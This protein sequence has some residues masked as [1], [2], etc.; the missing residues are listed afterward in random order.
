MNK[1]AIAVLLF[2]ILI[3][4]SA[5][6]INGSNGK[7]ANE[8]SPVITHIENNITSI[9]YSEQYILRH[10]HIVNNSTYSFL[11]NFIL[12]QHHININ[13][14]SKN[15]YTNNVV[16][17]VP[18][19]SV[20]NYNISFIYPL[21]LYNYLLP[22]HAV[23][24]TQQIMT[25]V[26]SGNHFLFNVDIPV[27]PGTTQELYNMPGVTVFNSTQTFLNEYSPLIP[28]TY[29]PNNIN[30]LPNY[31]SYN[32]IKFK[33][34][35]QT[36]QTKNST[37]ATVWYTPT[38]NISAYYANSSSP[39]PAY[40]ITFTNNVPFNIT[41]AGTTYT[42]QTSLTVSEPNGTYYYTVTYN[43]STYYSTVVVSGQNIQVNI[44]SIPII[45]NTMAYLYLYL[46]ISFIGVMALLRLSQGFISIYGMLSVM[47]VYLGYRLQVEYFNTTLIAIIV[48]MLC[49]FISYKVVL[50]E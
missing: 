19:Q 27:F 3:G 50:E 22:K 26:L 16:S 33:Y 37:G 28:N 44:K 29:I 45:I 1:Q 2:L 17:T 10:S 25:Y 20:I 4:I 40:Q 6:V 38:Y 35:A 8:T 23:I 39:I 15:V 30:Q 11:N 14:L 46:A 48:T 47:I 18:E 5:I 43:G 42:D 49:A 9:Y 34:N 41:I 21:N 7:I 24:L 36:Y 12:N 31:I 13:K 32:P